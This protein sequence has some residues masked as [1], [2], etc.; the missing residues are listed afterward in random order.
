MFPKEFSFDKVCS[1]CGS[2]FIGKAANSLFCN[3][4]K[5]DG[6]I[7]KCN[8][9]NNTFRSKYNGTKYCKTCSDKKVFQIGKPLSEETRIKIGNNR[10]KWTKSSEGVLH[11]KKLGAKNSEN[12]IRYFKTDAGKKQIQSA[13]KKQ[14]KTLRNKIK[15]GDF[16][17]NITNSWTHWDAI[18][19]NGNEV[20]KFRSSWE[21]CFWLSN[22][23]YEYET[24]RVNSLIDEDKIY[25]AD[26]YDKENRILFEIKPKG[27]FLKKKDKMDSLMD[28]CKN[29]DIKFIWIN[30]NNILYYIN[31][32]IFV[33]NSQIKQLEKLKKGISNGISKTENKKNRKNR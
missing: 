19:D 10:K 27:E 20:R 16:T 32:D 11:Y 7:K 6:I 28:Y 8:Y 1:S 30:E 3:D 24:V 9:C 29:N 2:N 14:S 26:F 23:N 33:T 12:L 21:A 25:I 4:C 22:P 18:I 17:P 15:N 13:A 5:K 31:E